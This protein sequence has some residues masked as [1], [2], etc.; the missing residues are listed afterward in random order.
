[1]AIIGVEYGTTAGIVYSNLLNTEDSFNVTLDSNAENGYVISNT[2]QCSAL[3]YTLFSEDNTPRTVTIYISAVYL[4]AQ[5]AFHYPKHTLDIPT[6]KHGTYFQYT[7]VP[8]LFNVA[9]LQ[10]PPGFI[11]A[12]NCCDCLLHRKLFDDC[13]IINESGYFSWCINEWV[14]VYDSGI[15]YD[16]HC[17]FDYCNFT[18]ERFIDLQ[19]N[20]DSQCAFNRAGR[21]CGGYKEGYSL[22]IGSS[23]CIRC[24][25][26]NNLALLIFFAAS[27]VLLVLFITALNLTVKQGMINGLIFY[28]NVVWTYQSIFFQSNQTNKL[29]F[30]KIFIAWL[31]LDFGIM[32]CFASRLT[33]FWKTLLQFVFPFYVWAIAWLII[34][35][36]KRSNFLGE[37][38]VSVLCTLFLLSYTKLL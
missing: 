35:V 29:T 9:I 23:H 32:T 12:D 1:M 31:N 15:L 16:T 18:T 7:L 36:S 24:L 22:A 30:L 19:N 28:A 25:N 37:R 13:T 38:S 11:L 20:S 26:N 5:T 3:N 27:G 10:C 2:K 8:I 33:A 6:D 4:D 17:P 14:T 21:L 34:V